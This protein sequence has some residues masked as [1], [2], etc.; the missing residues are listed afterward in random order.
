MRKIITI[1]NSK[2]TDFS[3]N[4]LA[5]LDKCIRCEVTEELN[6]LYEL[7][8]EYPIFDKKSNY[9]IKDNIIKAN[10]PNGY[11]LFRIYRPVK[12]MGVIVCYTR[13][14]FYDL[15]DNFVEDS[16]PTEL[17]GNDALQYILKSTQ[18]E[19]NFKGYSNISKKNTAYYIRKNPVE[20]LL[21]ESGNSFISRWG[22]EL[23]RDNF[24][25]SILNSI[26]KDNG[27]TISYG[28]NLLGLEEDLDNSEVVTRIMPTG[29]T[30]ND[31]VIML[32]EKY[33][34][35]PNLDKYPFPK[36]RHLHFSD[37]KVDS[38][39]G[40]TESDVKR[41]LREKVQ[42]LYQIQHIDVPKA[43]YKVDFIELSKTEEYKK[44]SCLEKVSLGDI[45]TV[46]HLKMG[47]DIRQ[48]VIKY[49]W[50]SILNKYLEIE[51]GSFKENLSTDLSNLSNSIDEVK[52][53]LENS[54]KQFRSK[55]EQTDDR[56]TLTVEEIGKTNT[57]LELTAN[58]I[59]ADVEDK[60]AQ[61]NSKIEQTATSL[62]SEIN[63]TRDNLSSKIEQTE[64]NITSSVNGQIR[65][66]DGK[67]R[68]CNS[69]IEQNADSI[70]LVVKHGQVDGDELVSAINLSDS[71]IDMSALNINLN[72]YVTF[73]N[74]ENGE[75]T[76]DGSC[77][78][79]GIL[80]AD[81]IVKI[82]DYVD[83]KSS[84]SINA[85]GSYRGSDYRDYLW[86]LATKGIFLDTSRVYI[87][88]E[89]VAT[90]EWVMEQLANL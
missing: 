57:K 85:I 66:V 67:I 40:I 5:V 12:N 55:F 77:I 17:N 7:E 81:R 36:I 79:T 63:N 72:G 74:L 75:T 53:S 69:K 31:S 43:N 24:N 29:L 37:I 33:I 34:D 35:S 11:Q 88:D 26:G 49:K 18:Y 51:L 58:S 76:V 42:E 60:Y 82:S 32:E 59:T 38:E 86:L 80:E 83:I 90:R 30:E 1:Y 39:K 41:M 6:G 28:K 45:V 44:Y 52:E 71:K 25:V 56:I 89:R 47:I 8:L 64:K 9:L 70:Y 22:G 16:R 4:G 10:T 73:S 87:A 84:N 68:D 50:D 15:F 14:I 61:T 48:K 21:S 46:K 78:R 2:E 65:D 19:H 3:H 54:N 62:T 13:H 27:V 20:I 23:L